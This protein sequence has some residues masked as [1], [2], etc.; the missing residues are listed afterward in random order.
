VGR[1]R[2]KEMEKQVR[3]AIRESQSWS[4]ALR[5]LDLRPAGGNHLTLKKWVVSWGIDTSHFDPQAELRNRERRRIRLEEVLIES[6]T[7]SRRSLKK[8]LYAE[9]L[10]RPICEECGQDEHWRG[11]RM[12]LILDHINGVPDD[13]RLENL[14]VLCPNCAATLETHC[15]RKN[16]L[17]ERPCPQC[18]DRFVPSR[19]GQR[20]CSARCA[21]A[22]TSIRG[23]PRPE[24][25]K[26]TRPPYE[27]LLAEIEAT[28]YLAVGRKYGVSGTA[29]RKWVRS[30][31]R[32][33]ERERRI[34]AAAEAG[35]EPLADAA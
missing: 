34:A 1:L 12:A 17:D 30:Y 33:A 10:K 13:H 26:V 21:S 3:I 9:G 29:V 8:R 19:F 25:R 7:Y 15:G 22:S 31:E 6:S 35:D 2:W 28:S 20:F 27:Q 4:E 14:R 16:R 32:Q 5:R 18:G 11:K 24:R 23:I